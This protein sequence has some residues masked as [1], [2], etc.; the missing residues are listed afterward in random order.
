MVNRHE[1]KARPWVIAIFSFS[2]AI[3]IGVIWEIVE[4]SIDSFFGF[5]MQKSGLIDTMSDLI[6][7][8]VGAMFASAIAFFY[9]KSKKAL[10]FGNIVK[11]KE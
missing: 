3:A 11:R 9:L 8:A 7:D 1:L 10:I 4:F 5:N 2:F 6:V